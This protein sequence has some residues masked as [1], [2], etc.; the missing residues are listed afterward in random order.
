M[1][2]D[3]HL[4]SVGLLDVRATI[5]N[6]EMKLAA[7][8]A[9]AELARTPVPDI[10]NIAL[11]YEQY[12]FRPSYIIPKP[13]DPRLLS[14]VAPAVEQKQPLLQV[15]HNQISLTGTTMQLS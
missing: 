9:L 5:I 7:V 10:V 2:W 11:Q 6:E 1:Y 8:H 14:T 4:F 12:C 3:F 13:L 15:L